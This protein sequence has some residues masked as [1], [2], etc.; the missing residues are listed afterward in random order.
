MT[1][2]T[3]VTFFRP[4]FNDFLYAAIG[5][6]RNGMPLSVLSALARL[7][8]DPWEEAAELAELSKDAA[9]RRLALLIERLPAGRWAQ[10]DLRAIADRL[11]ALLPRRGSSKVSLV[12]EP[13]GLR[14]L[15]SSTVA[16]ILICTALV[17]TTLI[18]VAASREP[19]SRDDQ[20]DAPVFGTAS[21]PQMSTPSSR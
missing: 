20:V 11:I 17:V 9:T 19:R 15:T 1:P 18:F 14:E 4:E 2:A 10:T 3:S 16:K 5:A 7:D 6:D 8:V 12:G 13:T 21:P